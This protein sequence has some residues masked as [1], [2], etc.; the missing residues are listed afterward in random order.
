MTEINQQPKNANLLTPK[1]QLVAWELTQRCNL[2]CAHCRGSST[3]EVYSNELTL[4]ESYRLVDQILEVGNPILILTGGE[5]LSH[6]RFFD[7]ANYASGKGMRV[8]M[9]S[10]GTMITKEIAAKFKEVPIARLG[11]SLDFPNAAEQDKFRGMAGAFDGALAGIAYA[12]EAGIPI[13]INCTVTKLNVHHLDKLV[14]LAFEVGAMAFHPFLLVPT[15]RGKALEAVEL[16]PEEYERTLNWIYD[17]QKE[18]GDRMFFKPTDAPHYLRVMKQRSKGGEQPPPQAHPG[19]GSHPAKGGHPTNAISRGCLAGLGFCFV[20]GQGKVKGCGYF[21][22]EAGDVREN[23][24]KDIW[25]NSHLF[26][27]LR[28][29]TNLKGKCGV[30]EYKRICGGC[31][32]RAYESTGDCLEAEPYCIYEPPAWKKATA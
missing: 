6:P 27:Q 28:D 11:V 10:N 17:K 23:T 30:C 31:R 29:L 9:G 12:R 14:D 4:D 22:I 5:P 7:I 3:S 21:D 26:N 2:L 18:L 13:Q 32:A 19:K 8:V 20:S 16:P 24:F 25:D 1:L 15:G